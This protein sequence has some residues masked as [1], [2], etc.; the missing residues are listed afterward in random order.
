MREPEPIFADTLSLSK[1]LPLIPSIKYRG[2]LHDYEFG[3]KNPAGAVIDFKNGDCVNT[4]IRMLSEYQGLRVGLLNMASNVRPGGGVVHGAQAQ[5]EDICR[6]TNLYLTIS[7]QTYPLR[8]DDI[9]CSPDIKVLKTSNY[10]ELPDPI[11]IHGVLSAAAL[12]R[13]ETKDNG[14]LY[15]NDQ[16][17]CV[18]R[19]KIQLLLQ[20]AAYHKLDCLV[21]GAWGCGAFY[22]PVNEVAK[23]FAEELK[24][25]EVR[26][27][28]KH[29][30]FAI[31]DNPGRS[32]CNEFREAFTMVLPV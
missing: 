22:N 16:D 28:F 1:A 20:T 4:C 5:E 8:E 31:R 25:T 24:K 9:L 3:N 26:N 7:K 6:R 27:A 19:M 32:L 21:L 11:T 10:V 15:S 14:L 13:P 17:R 12:R 2:L 29:V 30:T 18:M 23:L